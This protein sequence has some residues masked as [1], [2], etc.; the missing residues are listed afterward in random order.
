MISS[1]IKFKPF[2]IKDQRIRPDHLWTRFLMVLDLLLDVH[3][4]YHR[5]S[6]PFNNILSSNIVWRTSQCDKLP[7]RLKYKLHHP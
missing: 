1:P 3:T 2:S 4:I 7:T 5:I 6:M